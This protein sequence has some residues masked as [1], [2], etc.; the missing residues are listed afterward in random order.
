[1]VLY[2]VTGKSLEMD[3][4]VWQQI[5]AAATSHGWQP[6]GTATPPRAVFPGSAQAPLSWVGEYAQPHGQ[7]VTRRDAAALASSLRA[8]T[9]STS[10]VD[11]PGAL[12][13]FLELCDHGGFIICTGASLSDPQMRAPESQF[14][15]S[16]ASLAMSL[17]AAVQPRKSPIPALQK[18]PE[19]VHRSTQSR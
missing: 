2:G 15:H 12:T 3:A 9:N 17:G 16:L 5:L 10:A 18:T 7:E 19:T 8:F 4:T 1:M 11:I 13:P 14:A 6:K